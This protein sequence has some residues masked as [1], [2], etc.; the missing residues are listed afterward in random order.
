VEYGV[1]GKTL[2]IDAKNYP[3]LATIED[4]PNV[5]SLCIQKVA[6]DFLINNITIEQ[7]E[8]ISY[9]EDSVNIL[10]QFA[11]LYLKLK[12]VLQG[13]YS[14]LLASSPFYHEL[15][16]IINSLDK[17][18]VYD[19][20]STYIKLKRLY[21]KINLIVS[22]NQKLVDSAHPLLQ[23]LSIFLEEFERLPVYSLIKDFIPGYKVGDRSIYR[24]IFVADIRPKFISIK[25]LSKIPEGAEILET[26]NIDE[27]TEVTIFKKQGEML[28]HYY[29]FPDEYKL[30]EQ[31]LLLVNRA[32]DVLMQYQPRRE[33]YI[34]PERLQE[35]Y[36]KISE[37]IL[38]SL[39]KT[40]GVALTK[41]KMRRLKNILVRYTIGFGILE[42]IAKDER[43]QDI[44]V[45]PPPGTQPI[46]LIHADYELCVTNVIPTKRE[47]DSWATKLRLISGRPFD[48]ANPV[49]DTEINLNE[50][51]LRVAAII[52]P[53]SPK[54]LSYVFRRH[55]SRPW[56]LPL[57]IKNKMLS[58]L[59][60]GLLSFLVESGRTLLIAGTRGA[61]KTSLLTSLMLEIPRSSRILTIEDTLEIPTDY[62][63]KLGYNIV[64]MKVR[65]PF[66]LQT[67]EVSAEDGVR[68][69]LRLGDSAI[70]LGEVRSR[71]AKVLY[72]AMRVGALANAVM[73]TIHA[74]SPYGVYDRVVNDLGVPRTSFKATDI[75]VIAN[76]IK[77][78][79]G[80]KKYRRVLRITEVRKHWE[81]DPLK[82]RGFVDLMI[83]NADKDSLTPTS[84]L[85]NGDSDILKSIA[86][87]IRLLAGS[88]ER[89]WNSIQIR[90]RSKEILV[91]YSIK[92]DKPE[93][94]EAEFVV[95]ANEYL[96]NLI[97]ES[98]REYGDILV[99]YILKEYEKWLSKE[100]R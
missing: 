79:D 68:V 39:S 35:I 70:I 6:E 89:V 34:D 53:L 51:R 95:K 96:H 99:D 49:L 63:R 48:E 3:K 65:S 40:Y 28:C 81:R 98:V 21:R 93:I 72:E 50:V 25:Y 54:G 75:I 80:L 56:T 64:P 37:N 94:L 2:I 22:K 59:A 26:Y 88:W 97:G 76:P 33:D 69:S 86:S 10:K 87:R 71:E 12:Q 73:G 55:R 77:S 91:N 62:F 30:Y 14:Y 9:Y 7:E 46:S 41:S 5:M 60:A 47:L 100:I 42:K 85:L 83:Y 92:H 4:D 61:G 20:I 66:S 29:V 16:V 23:L 13:Y 17:E 1:D 74:E 8:E 84:N 58:P 78:P 27:D 90:A 45:N 32:R 31:E 57:F 11:H 52:N 18:F 44:F 15:R 24:R 19:P 43:V 82:E 67:T 36:N 38:T